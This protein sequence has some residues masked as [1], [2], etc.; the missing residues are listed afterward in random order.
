MKTKRA[1]FTLI[2]LLVVIAIIAILAAM[3]LPAL[4]KAKQKAQGIQCLSNLRQ[5]CLGW[6]MYSGDNQDRLV[7]NGDEN[8]QPASPTDPAGQSGGPLAQWC[9]GRQDL[10][11]DLSPANG[12]ANIGGDWIKAGLIYP[13]VNTLAIYKCP[14]DQSFVSAF[15]AQLPHVRSM[16]M[17]DWLSPIKVWGGDP[18]PS[19]LTIYYK[20]SL[21]NNPRIANTWVFI[22]ENP[23]SINDA[24]FI[25][26]PQIANWIDYP[27]TYH[28][29]AGGIAFADGH[30]QIKKWTDTTVL[31]PSIQPGNVNNTHIAPGQNP[32]VELNWLQAASTA[33]H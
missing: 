30:A 26:D 9:P 20:E 4:A 21:L 29:N 11:A 5:L 12:A 18:N 7:P 24:S 1:G 17:N 19:A 23:L 13:Y 28:N 27:A 32:P 25:C 2:E 15:G 33:L 10:S 8:N 14:A 31:H 6:K 16:S 3:L 22:D